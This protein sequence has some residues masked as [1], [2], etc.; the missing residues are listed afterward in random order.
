MHSRCFLYIPDCHKA[1]TDQFPFC[2]PSHAPQAAYRQR[3]KN[4]RFF[5][6]RY[7]KKSVRLI[8]IACHFR[9]EFVRRDTYR[10]NKTHL[11]K[12]FLFNGS[13]HFS[14]CFIPAAKPG[15]IHK[16]FVQ[17][18]RLYCY[19]IVKHDFMD[20][21]RYRLVH[22]HTGFHKNSVRAKQMSP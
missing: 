21:L 14:Q 6:V 2:H 22:F 16:C 20:F 1:R 10:S 9:Q 12:Y 5:S 4:F 18:N 17:G 7:D 19:R 15:Y 13:S 11:F 3:S 8:H